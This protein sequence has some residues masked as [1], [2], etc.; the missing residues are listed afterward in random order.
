[1]AKPIS[2]LYCKSQFPNRD[3]LSKRI[4]RIHNGTGL[5]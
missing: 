4:D 2:C 1:M 5:L 3:D